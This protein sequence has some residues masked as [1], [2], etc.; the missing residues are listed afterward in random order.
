V[1]VKE[2]LVHIQRHENAFYVKLCMTDT[3]WWSGRIQKR[4]S[5]ISHKK[6]VLVLV[7]VVVVVVLVVLVVVVVLVVLKSYYGQ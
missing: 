1:V 3:S 5:L 6:V 7:V 2:K 4:I